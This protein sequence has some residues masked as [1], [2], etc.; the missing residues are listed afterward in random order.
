MVMEK[1]AANQANI[2]SLEGQISR[3]TERK[4]RIK[5]EIN[6]IEEKLFEFE[7]RDAADEA[8]N[9]LRINVED[10]EEK[11]K[12]ATRK[13]EGLGQ[14]R[15]DQAVQ[16]EEKHVERRELNSRLIALE[17]EADS[18]KV[19]LADIEHDEQ[20]PVLDQI[21]VEKGY[22]KALAS[23]LG[24]DNCTAPTRKNNCV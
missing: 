5:T 8:I 21:H 17:T 2:V 13:L 24:D 19:L 3:T 11:A 4:N 1:L 14:A 16:V 7:K 10:A 9:D 18:L 23:A 22:E 15:A 12:E 6:E 20:I